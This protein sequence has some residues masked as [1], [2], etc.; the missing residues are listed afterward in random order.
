MFALFNYNFI[1]ITQIKMVDPTMR[2]AAF[3]QPDGKM[4]E[5]IN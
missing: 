3:L 4:V 1:S 5:M 2:R